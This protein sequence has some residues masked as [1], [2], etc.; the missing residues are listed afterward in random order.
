[1]R[2][3]PDSKASTITTACPTICPTTSPPSQPAFLPTLHL[4][5]RDEH[6]PPFSSP[7]SP[8]ASQFSTPSPR[9]SSLLTTIPFLH[10]APQ[11]PALHN[12]PPASSPHTRDSS[13]A[14]RTHRRNSDKCFQR[15]GGRIFARHLG[16]S[17]SYRPMIRI[18]RGGGPGGC[19]E[20]S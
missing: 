1:M 17:L 11:L 14:A 4:S 18:R 10:T 3:M 9:F 16:V 19:N 20:G 2:S 13:Q 8:T 15:R 6:R 12:S 7:V 5:N